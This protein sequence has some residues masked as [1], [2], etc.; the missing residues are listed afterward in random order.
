MV[1]RLPTPGGLLRHG[2]APDHPETK[3]VHSVFDAVAARPGFRF[4][5]GVE[6]GRHITAEQLRHWYDAVIY[7]VGAA[8]DTRLGIPGEELPGV[9]SAREFVAWYNGHPDH[10]HHRFDLAGRR[11]VVIG[12]GNVALDIARMLTAEPDRLAATDIADHALQAL[13]SNAIREVVV[14]GRRGPQHGAFNNPELAELGELGLDI[15]VDGELPSPGRYAAETARKLATLSEYAYRRSTGGPRIVL[16]F[17]TSPVEIQGAGR[18]EKLVVERNRVEAKSGSVY[19]TGERSTMATH[20]VLRAVG[21][22]G[23]PVAGLPF[24]P[25]RGVVPNRDGRVEP[26]TYVTGW[27]RRGP[28]GIIGINKKCARDTVR[29]LLADARA[30]A[31]PTAGTLDAAAAERELRH[32]CPNVVDLAGWRRVDDHERRSGHQQ[33]RPRVKLTTTEQLRD[34]ARAPQ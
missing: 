17:L 14:L 28:R 11:A 1:E 33:R 26:G 29:T 31:L 12:N 10:R 25:E 9:H 15:T 30:G 34:V 21:Y 20:L 4:F 2:V 19:P 3:L 22:F 13:R 32:L 6:L 23:V 18:V 5:G 27:I 24:S 16:R 7:A 8:G